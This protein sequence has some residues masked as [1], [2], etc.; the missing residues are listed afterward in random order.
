MTWTKA[1]GKGYKH[2]E[3]M[4]HSST[5]DTA[6]KRLC[7]LFPV[8]TKLHAVTQIYSRPQSTNEALQEYIQRF[9]D[10]VIHETGT[11]PTSVTCQVIIALFMTHF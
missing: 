8:V 11:E 4:Q 9:T 6:K 3:G 1:E 10:V 5:W 2:I 7:Q